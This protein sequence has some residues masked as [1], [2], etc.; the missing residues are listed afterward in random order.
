MAKQRQQKNNHDVQSTGELGP[1]AYN[2]KDTHR[3]WNGLSDADLKQL[4]VVPEATGLQ[5]GAVYFD[6]NDPDRGEIRAHGDMVAGP[7]NRYVA[8]SAVPYPLWNAL[9]GVEEPERLNVGDER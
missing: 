3:L 4:P 9:I 6:L 2:V 8:K 5:E 1:S 7:E